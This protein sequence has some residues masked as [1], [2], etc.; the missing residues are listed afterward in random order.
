[1]DDLPTMTPRD[2]RPVEPPRE[3]S[4][5][6][7]GV[8]GLALNVLATLCLPLGCLSWGLAWH[9]VAP[10]AVGG[11]AFSLAAR[12]WVRT[13]GVVLG[14]AL[15]ALGIAFWVALINVPRAGG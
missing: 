6:V 11:A 12:G 8:L 9:G 4:R 15:A 10:L 3:P 1:M 5:T 14:V 13:V 7:A 2:D